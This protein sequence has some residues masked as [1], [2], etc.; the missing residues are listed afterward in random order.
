MLGPLLPG[1]FIFLIKLLFKTQKLFLVVAR[2]SPAFRGGE[3]LLSVGTLGGI[4]RVRRS[5][6]CSWKVACFM[7]AGWCSLPE[8]VWRVLV[9][10]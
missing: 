8:E 10:V 6:L 7:R 1:K 3:T 9:P 2:H 5:R 4:S